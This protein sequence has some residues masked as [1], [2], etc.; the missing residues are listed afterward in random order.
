MAM[1]YDETRSMTIL[2]GDMNAERAMNGNSW[3]TVQ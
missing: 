2:I 1:V 3:R